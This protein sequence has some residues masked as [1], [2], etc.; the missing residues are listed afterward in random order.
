MPK[1]LKK[2]RT[3][4]IPTHLSGP[5]KQ[6]EHEKTVWQAQSGFTQ[7]AR[8]YDRELLRIPI[9]LQLQ[10]KTFSGYS[11]DFSPAGLGIILQTALE[12]GTPLALQCT[13]GEVCY[14]NLSAQVVFCQPAN[15]ASENFFLLGIKFSAIRDWEEK[16]LGSAIQ[17]LK[18]GGVQLEKSLLT[19]HVTE[20]TIALDAAEWYLQTKDTLAESPRTIRRSWIH[21]SKIIGWGS[22]LPPNEITNHDISTMLKVNG[23]KTNFGDVVGSLTGIKSRRYAS[24]RIYPSDLAV[25]ASIIALRNAGI[26]PKDLE[27]IISCGIARDT[28]EPATSYIIQ[29][30]LGAHNAYCFDISNACNGFLS[31]IDILDSFI[32]SGRCEI[33]LVAVGEV[34][35][36][37]VTWDAKSKKD[38]KLSSMGYT[39]GD[40]GG[41]AVLQRVQEGDERGIRARWF[42]S[43]G[44]YW[45]VAVVPLIDASKRL[46]K[47][48]AAG[49]ERI[50]SK[51]LPL[52]IEE[53]LKELQWTIDDIRL[54]IP[55]QVGIHVVRQILYK[56]FGIP[57]EKVSWPFPKYGNVGA[58]SMP[59]AVCEA[60]QEGRIGHGDK[61]LFVGG[62]GGFGAAIMGVTI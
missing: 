26:D 28:E 50:A 45:K 35:S 6:E 59:I 32:A 62:S 56:R 3:A 41:A 46:F 52:G 60:L 2:L 30:K 24:S 44:T 49:I 21:A 7:R 22:Y 53:V 17:E 57:A 36:Q 27:V 47:S 14:L 51:Y 31:A 58:A 37:Y 54:V 18:H 11:Y 20:D 19:V 61:V 23:V 8:M 4:Q 16:I 48:N 29:E 39:L 55:H 5:R 34:L 38:L 12:A 43:D 42:L 15:G 10:N 33:G 9:S 13:F 25:E 40:G 1:T